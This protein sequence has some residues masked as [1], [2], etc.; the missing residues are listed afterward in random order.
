[1][2]NKSIGLR[3]CRNDTPRLQIPNWLRSACVHRTQQ[4]S[5]IFYFSLLDQTEQF[6]RSTK[7]DVVAPC[8][9]CY[10]WYSIQHAEESK[11]QREVV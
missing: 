8:P 6:S 11:L 5:S 1:M 10:Y 3:D 9:P 4:A 2:Y 7:A